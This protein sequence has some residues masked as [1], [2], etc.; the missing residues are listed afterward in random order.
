MR[1]RDK[2]NLLWLHLQ[3]FNGH[4]TRQ[5]ADLFLEA[6]SLKVTLLFDQA[7]TMRSR[8]ELKIYLSPL[9]QDLRTLNLTGC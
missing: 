2:L 4:Q 5:G 6:P 1:S 7:T 3:K 9:S 8:D